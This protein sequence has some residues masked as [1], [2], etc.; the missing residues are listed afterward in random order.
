LIIAQEFLPTAF[1]WRI[2]ILDKQPIF[3]CKY[4]MA[5]KHW[6]IVKWDTSGQKDEG[7]VDTLPVEFVPEIVIKT[8]LKVSNLI[9][10]GLYGVDVKQ[11]NN[12]AYIVEV[13]DNPNVDYG[14]ED[15]VLKNELY[16][17]IINVF[18][19]RIEKLKERTY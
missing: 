7:K 16:S 15:A 18:V 2:G 5:K 10:D 4:Y 9:G 1:D 3:A 12:K 17:R 13:N 6:Q 14:L 8:A 19:R 11:V